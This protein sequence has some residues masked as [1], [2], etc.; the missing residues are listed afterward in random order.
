MERIHKILSVRSELNEKKISKCFSG[1]RFDCFTLPDGFCRLRSNK[2]K[3]ELG[4][5][6][7][8]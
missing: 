3:S 1:A 2:S 4:A 8:R 6:E 5:S 7:T